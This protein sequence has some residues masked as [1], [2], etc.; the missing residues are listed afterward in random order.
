MLTQTDW[1]QELDWLTWW[2]F[3]NPTI[4]A[5]ATGTIIYFGE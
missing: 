5:D 2:K 4:F 3:T 1:K